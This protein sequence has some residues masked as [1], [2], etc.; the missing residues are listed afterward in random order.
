M[1]IRK[2]MLRAAVLFT[3]IALFAC[4][5]SEEILATDDKPVITFDSDDYVYT[6]KVGS[7]VTLRPT[8]TNN[9]NAAYRWLLNG[10]TVGNRET[11][12]FT[13]EESG[14]YYITFEVST[15]AATVFEEVRIDVVE[16]LL[17]NIAMALPENGYILLIGTQKEFD[18]VVMNGDDA[19]F[20]WYVDGRKVADTRAYTFDASTAGEY[21]LLFRAINED[22]ECEA[23]FNVSVRSGEDIPF[24]WEWEKERFNMTVGRTVILGPWSVSNAFDAVY[25]WTLEG[26]TVYR[27][28]TPEYP[29]TPNRIG[30]YVFSV[31]MENGYGRF[32]EKKVTVN[33]YDNEAAN[34]RPAGA[35]SK[36][37]SY[38]VWE[39]LPAP[40]Q[41]INIIGFNNMEEASRFAYDRMA[42]RE[43][44]SLGAFGGYIIVGFDHSV[45]NDGGYN[46]QILGNSYDGS[47]EPGIVWVMQDENGDGLPNDTW[48]ELKG[49]EHG[50]AGTVQ[51]YAVTYYRPAASRMDTPWEDNL[52]STGVVEANRFHT[53]DYYYPDWVETPSYTLRGTRLENNVTYDGISWRMETY[54]W[55]YADNFGTDR[56][57]DDDNTEAEVNANHFRISDA[58]DANGNSVHLEYIDFVKVQVGVQG[59]A[60]IIGEVST[61]VYGFRDYNMI[62]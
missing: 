1:A 17:P 12:T 43:F 61:E 36:A 27:S 46:I 9:E 19:A 24:S 48:Y 45:V 25:T 57:T 39:Y 13:G 2:F 21:A 10:A 29:F 51:N 8:V 11:Y 31:C 20:G 52:G 4:N 49:S 62:K 35:G 7:S 3:G 44:L 6:I 55:G 33:V 18:P 30:E 41:F 53:Q 54:E 56:L 32:P 16:L 15:R 37:D 22:G 40:G 47:S 38:K 23:G 28:E 50:K 5:S 14:S 59:M 34:Y 42:A 60:G 58:V 26:N